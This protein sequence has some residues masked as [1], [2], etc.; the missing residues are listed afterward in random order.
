MTHYFE[1]LKSS[2]A[3][4]LA[5][6]WSG[7]LSDVS[8]KVFTCDLFSRNLNILCSLRFLL[9]LYNGNMAL[10]LKESLST[11]FYGL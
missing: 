7:E 3:L 4:I 5:N 6:R 2:S 9:Q 10:S 1:E 8:D 11:M